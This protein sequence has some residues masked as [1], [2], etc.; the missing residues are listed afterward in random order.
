MCEV[1]GVI[2]VKHQYCCD[3]QL[4]AGKKSSV[5][6]EL[7]GLSEFLCFRN[8][9]MFSDCNGEWKLHAIFVSA[10]LWRQPFP[11][12]PSL[13]TLQAVPQPV[14][15]SVL[16]PMPKVPRVGLEPDAVP[17]RRAGWLEQKPGAAYWR[18]WP[19]IRGS[20]RLPGYGDWPRRRCGC[21]AGGCGSILR[22]LHRSLFPPRSGCVP[23][24]PAR[25]RE[26]AARRRGCSQRSRGR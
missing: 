23:R 3:S 12:P 18:R 19:P 8:G 10:Y 21:R 6:A 7:A 15:Q 24:V 11:K 16:A 5:E 14:M 2:G 20:L 25:P 17:M 9:Q 26:T 4:R 13:I 22:F 1:Q